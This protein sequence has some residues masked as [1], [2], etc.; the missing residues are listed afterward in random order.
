MTIAQLNERITKAEEKINKKEATIEKKKALIAK[1]DVEIQ[2]LGFT[3]EIRNNRPESWTEASNKAF[4][5]AC[6]IVHLE[7]DLKRLPKEIE[8]IKATIEKYQ[9][10]LTG[11]IEKESILTKELPEVF[12]T[13]RSEL[14]TEWDRFDKDLQDNLRSEYKEIGYKDFIKKYT[15]SRYEFMSK[16]EDEIHK[17]NE[18]DAKALILDL[19][20]RVKAITGE[21]TDWSG[22]RAEMGNGG[23]TV[24]TGIVI[25]KTGRARVET[26]LAGGYNIQ[27]L[28]IRTLVHEIN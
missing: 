7:E 15:Y 12:T 5:L 11:E 21:V 14:V 1:K 6:D 18:R 3:R 8:E 26:I 24:L 2:K 4:W 13:L 16:T 25:G 10:Q 23:F 9:A 17:A 19:Y 27:R 28:H 20:N 22:I